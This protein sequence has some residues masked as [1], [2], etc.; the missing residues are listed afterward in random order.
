MSDGSAAVVGDR[1]RRPN[2]HRFFGHP[3]A[4]A[5]LFSTELWERFSF[6]GMR[7]ILTLYLAAPVA[8]GG[9]GWS[10]GD[11]TS[12]YG[13]YN[14]F[15]YLMA[16]PGA[17]LADRLIGARRSVLWGGVVIAMGHYLLAVPAHA[18]F[19]LGLIFIVCGTGL[20]KPNMSAMVGELYERDDPRRDAGFSLFY[21]GI[22][23]GAFVAPLIVGPLGQDVNWHL[24]FACAGIGMTIAVIWYVIGTRGMGD[25]GTVICKPLHAVDRRRLLRALLIGVVIAAVVVGGAQ[26]LFT[27]VFGKTSI[28]A[29][30]LIMALVP[31][32]VTV[33]YF[34]RM[35]ADRELTDVERSRLSAYVFL[36]V[37]A[38]C[39]WLIYDQAGSVVNLFTEHK[40]DLDLPLLGNVAASTFQSI[41]P[42]FIIIGSPLAAIVW[43]RLGHRLS[44]PSKFAFGLIFNGLSFV[45]MSFAAAAAVG[46]GRVSPLWIVAVYAIQVAGE[47]SISPVGLSATTKLA[48]ASYVSQM[49]GL[50]FLS[51]AVGD[52]IGGQIAG[53]QDRWGETAYFAILGGASVVLGLAAIGMVRS[54]R[55]LMRGIH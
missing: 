27:K 4:L 13:V 30:L 37:F 22:N 21:M 6:Y 20:L 26:L 47:L 32:L 52:G 34:S 5:T 36:F 10:S 11:A 1:P 15:V 17:W 8:A 50:W 53:L 54:L 35:F 41:N 3:W 18:T 51:T 46:G 2:D 45:V 29:F 42:I 14:G 19:F 23:I 31:V 24:G 28:S 9:W 33:V 55:G 43:L 44:T 38:A 7:A 12:L 39:F 25:V 16:L 48:P 49:L 40:V